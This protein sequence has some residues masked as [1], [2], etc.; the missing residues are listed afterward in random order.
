MGKT[1]ALFQADPTSNFP[2]RSPA[3]WPTQK[4]IPQGKYGYSLSAPQMAWE[5]HW[6]SV[7]PS[8][9]SDRATQR[10]TAVQQRRLP[11]NPASPSDGHVEEGSIISPPRKSKQTTWFVFKEEENTT[12][13]LRAVFTQDRFC[14][15]SGLL[16]DISLPKLFRIIL[17]IYYPLS[18]SCSGYRTLNFFWNWSIELYA[19]LAYIN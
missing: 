16:F 12:K 18:K 4:S 19:F 13:T 2:T 17:F 9:S 8:P 14:L 1:Y 3:Q 10:T 11:R 6:H 7:S 5:T 15:S